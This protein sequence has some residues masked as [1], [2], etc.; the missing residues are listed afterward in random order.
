VL[1]LVLVLVASTTVAA[2][3][4]TALRH[5]AA[6]VAVALAAPATTTA[7]RVVSAAPLSSGTVSATTSVPLVTV[8]TATPMV[9][10]ATVVV[11]PLTPCAAAIAAVEAKGLYSAPGF[12]VT[13]PGPSYGHLGM[14]CPSYDPWY[15]PTGKRVVITL[16]D[17]Y[18]VANEFS[19]SRCFAHLSGCYGIDGGG[20]ALGFKRPW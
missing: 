6:T 11:A 20:Q 16:P 2:V 8:T 3:V 10:A 9:T 5:H 14:T 7:P 1:V 19:N 17:P 4:V 15:C 12:P 13:C 18:V